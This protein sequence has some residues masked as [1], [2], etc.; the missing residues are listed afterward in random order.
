MQHVVYTIYLI[1]MGDIPR[2]TSHGGPMSR[3]PASCFGRSGNPKVMTL[4]L[5]PVGSKRGQVKPK[6][7]KFILVTS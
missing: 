2:F 4:S 3:A 5:K 7:L 6:T 1:M